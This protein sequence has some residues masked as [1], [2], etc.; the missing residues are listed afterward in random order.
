MKR[1]LV[2]FLLVTM[3]LSALS[4]CKT[5][6]QKAKAQ[7]LKEIKAEYGNEITE[8]QAEML[9]DLYAEEAVY[10]EQKATQK[11]EEEPRECPQKKEKVEERG[12]DPLTFRMLS[13]RS[14][15]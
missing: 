12:I 15:I 2:L 7:A 13:G 6:E 5:T 11:K 1:K 8:E 14:T 9:A 3:S 4:G 10:Q